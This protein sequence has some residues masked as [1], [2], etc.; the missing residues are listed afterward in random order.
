VAALMHLT[1]CNNRRRHDRH[2]SA[3]AHVFS[4]PRTFV[5]WRRTGRSGPDIDVEDEVSLD[6]LLL[7]TETG[8]VKPLHDFPCGSTR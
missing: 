4:V 6:R 3:S 8:S 2:G 1:V 5:A 7:A